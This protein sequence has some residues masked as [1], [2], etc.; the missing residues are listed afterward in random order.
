MRL[1]LLDADAA[2]RED[3]GRAA[4][5][6]W[7]F[8]QRFGLDHR[9]E[10]G[11]IWR[12]EFEENTRKRAIFTKLPRGRSRAATWSTQAGTRGWSATICTGLGGDQA[13]AESIKAEEGKC[14]SPT[15]SR[16]KSFDI[17]VES[18]APM[19][20]ERNGRGRGRRKGRGDES[21][22]RNARQNIFNA[23]PC[24][25]RNSSSYA[26]PKCHPCG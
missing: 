23:N 11:A 13:G 3:M 12:S 1:E 19:R 2:L 8:A 16:S 26:L 15:P 22:R 5:P 25:P 10:C 6:A 17:G 20:P 18:R 21:Q 14:L 4:K 24:V 9:L 7:F